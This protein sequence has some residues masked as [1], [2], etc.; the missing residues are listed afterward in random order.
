MNDFNIKKQIEKALENSLLIHC[1]INVKV[2]NGEAILS[3][4]VDRYNKKE[5]AKK[6]A[7]EVEGIR[8]VTESLI[9]ELND[10]DIR[11]D[12]EI[13]TAIHEKF[14]KNFG[15]AH[16]DVHVSVRNGYVSLEGRLAWKY[17]KDLAVECISS[18]NGI[19]DINN[20]IFIPETAESLVNEK[21]VL[22]AIYSDRSITSDIKV[23]IFRYKVIVKGSIKNR[24]QK[25][26][27][28]RLVRSVAGVNEVENFLTID[29]I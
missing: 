23:E 1:E 16:T 22:A 10:S 14:S 4:Y 5:V 8:L 18:I 27:V 19:K 12:S 24:N 11:N 20:N 3:G 25:N 2:E 13:E 7:H 17:Q 28:T 15:Y 29:E 26:L 9:V 21:D 6:I